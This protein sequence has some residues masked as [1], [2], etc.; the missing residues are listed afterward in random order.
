MWIT[1]SYLHDWM[2]GKQH[3]AGLMDAV[4]GLAYGPKH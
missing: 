1:G 3:P 4:R 2:T